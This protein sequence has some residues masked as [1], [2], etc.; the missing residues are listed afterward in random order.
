M[1]QLGF[2]VRC[3]VLKTHNEA[4]AARG[5]SAEE[6]FEL[7]VFIDSMNKMMLVS[8]VL[9]CEKSSESWDSVVIFVN[10]VARD[11]PDREA[12]SRFAAAGLPCVP[13]GRNRVFPKG[14][15]PDWSAGCTWAYGNCTHGRLGRPIWIEECQ[16]SKIVIWV[17]VECMIHKSVRWRNDFA[18]I[19]IPE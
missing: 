10:N 9:I 6:V 13:K 12:V 15:Q 19:G 4:P 2:S 1:L 18:S 7:F 8:I 17:G 3:N 14:R 11:A 5:P 16:G